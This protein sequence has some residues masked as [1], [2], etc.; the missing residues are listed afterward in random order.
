MRIIPAVSLCDNDRIAS[1]RFA[2]GAA[3]PSD[4]MSTIVGRL[5]RYSSCHCEPETHIFTKRNSLKSGS[6]VR[7]S[8]GRYST[9]TLPDG[10]AALATSFRKREIWRVKMQR[11]ISE[12]AP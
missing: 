2:T 7:R 1:M 3:R 8:G 5:H 9:I 10:S 4:L 6:S 11:T 12:N